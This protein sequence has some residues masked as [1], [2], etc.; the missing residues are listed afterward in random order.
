MQC[1]SV[2]HGVVLRT[3]PYRLDFRFFVVATTL[4]DPTQAWI[5]VEHTVRMWRLCT[6]A[7]LAEMP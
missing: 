6:R 3:Q 2:R 7:G 4:S 1:A 5:G